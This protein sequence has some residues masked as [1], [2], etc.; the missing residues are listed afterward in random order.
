MS[1]PEVDP[2]H[3][4]STRHIGD[5]SVLIQGTLDNAG[6]HGNQKGAIQLSRIDVARGD[7]PKRRSH[8]SVLDLT[9]SEADC[10]GM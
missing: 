7:T 10:N 6:V 8:S 2:V 5:V 4:M 1:Q 9:L 3:R